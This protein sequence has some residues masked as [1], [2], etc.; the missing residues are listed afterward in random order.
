MA[1]NFGYELNDIDDYEDQT[2]IYMGDVDRDVIE[3]TFINDQETA[4]IIPYETPKASGSNIS[5]LQRE[6]LQEIVEKFFKDV[7]YE[8]GDIALNLDRFRVKNGVL[9]FNKSSEIGGYEDWINLTNK[10]KGL[11][12]PLAMSSIEKIFNQ[13]IRRQIDIKKLDEIVPTS[14]E[15]DNMQ[16]EELKNRISDLQKQINSLSEYKN[17]R[18]LRE[19]KSLDNALTHIEGDFINST[20]K[21]TKLKKNIKIQNDKLKEPSITTEQR[22]VIEKQLKIL[23]EEYE[24]FLETLSQQKRELQSQFARIRQTINKIADKDRSLKERLNILWRE[25]GLTIVS[26]LTAIGMTVTTL[27]LALLP[28][29]GS[30]N[31]P[32]KARDWVKKGLKALARVF[33]RIAKWALAALPGAIGSII[34][35]IFTF[36]KTVVTKAGEHVYALIGFI[37]ALISY[38]MIKK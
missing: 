20:S 30:G 17:F 24:Q 38:Y 19:L 13:N 23:K 32:H 21:L 12:T 1:T 10:K 5:R 26:V 28:K 16:P 33:G 25:Q 31:N 29:G 9:E 35:W 2:D 37:A 27:V 6:N 14:R 34:S 36:L 22:S 15:V 7:G 18:P 4:D 3:T 8:I 11:N